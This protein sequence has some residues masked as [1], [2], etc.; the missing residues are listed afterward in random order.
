MRWRDSSF[1][2][3][4]ILISFASSAIGTKIIMS[5][6]CGIITVVLNQVA[7]DTCMT[8]FLSM[9]EKTERFLTEPMN[10][11][12]SFLPLTY[13]LANS[14]NIKVGTCL[15]VRM[16]NHSDEFDTAWFKAY[17]SRRMVR[18]AMSEAFSFSALS[19]ISLREYSRHTQMLF[20]YALSQSI[21]LNIS[22][23]CQFIAPYFRQTVISL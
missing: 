15:D 11:A 23:V 2:Y 12:F 3:L 9:S 21:G 14:L 19:L 10:L 16:P 1:V 4:S 8:T 6:N 20:T 18:F 5:T 17:A 22:S 7:I 13:L